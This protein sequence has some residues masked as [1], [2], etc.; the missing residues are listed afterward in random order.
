LNR[1][2]KIGRAGKHA[3]KHRIDGVEEIGTALGGQR[4]GQGNNERGRAGDLRNEA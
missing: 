2:L 4:A 1:V 3:R